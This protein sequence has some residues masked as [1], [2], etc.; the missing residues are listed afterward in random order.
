MIIPMLHM[1]SWDTNKVMW[2][3]QSNTGSQTKLRELNPEFK[4]YAKVLPPEI[5]FFPLCWEEGGGK[6]K[7]P[8]QPPKLAGDREVRKEHM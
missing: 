6:G 5:S 7:V 3:A 4:Y 1:R 2:L 8:I